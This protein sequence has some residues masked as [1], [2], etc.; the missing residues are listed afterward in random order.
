[1]TGTLPSN[2]V[3]V[4]LSKAVIYGKGKKPKIL[5]EK[6]R[7]GFVPYINI[8][9][10]EKGVIDE[11]ADIGSSRLI[12]ENDILVVWDGARFGL[13]GMGI[14]GAAGSTLMVL[15]PVVCNSKYLYSFINRYYSYINSKPKGTGTPHVNPDVFWKLLIPIAPLNEQKRIVAKL[16]AVI[17][18]IAAVKERLEKIPAI[19]KRFRQS[20]LA[21]AITGK[22]TEKWRE[23]NPEVKIAEE[24]VKTLF[25]KRANESKTT[26]QKRKIEDLYSK[27]ESG[28]NEILPETWRYIFLNKLCDSFQYG[29]S[30]K[31]DKEG[32]VPVLRMGNLQN[33]KIDWKDLVYTS[34]D[35]EIRKY[36]L[37][38]KTVLFNRTN[39]PELVGKTSIYEA[40]KKAIFAGYLIRINNYNVLDSYYL[41]YCLNTSY[42]K[43][44]CYGQKTD[45]VSQSNINAQKLAHFEIPFPPIEEQKEIVCQVDKFFALADKV[46]NHYQKARDRVDKLSQSVL[47]KA[48][49]GELVP[50]DPNDEPAEKLLERILAEKARMEAELK[51]AVRQKRRAPK[52]N[53]SKSK[54]G[55]KMR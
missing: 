15:K 1:M 29:T 34:D 22:L 33:G 40:E 52:K 50:Q 44:F 3:S 4:E 5:S 45:G 12:D 26:I 49:R 43:E 54:S 51:G 46:E 2:W 19:L 55:V 20:V 32:K 42:A 6:N 27:M 11:F 18:R 7:E 24:I 21:S 13:T 17:P 41:N 37:D 14:T 16:D 48:F 8:K 23:L 9:A 31:S 39:S 47:A 38:D 53:R 25:E 10:F 35:E 30:K 28:D 36:C